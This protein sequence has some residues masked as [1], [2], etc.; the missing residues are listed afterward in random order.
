MKN[1]KA[2]N[3]YKSKLSD[4]EVKEMRNFDLIFY[5]NLWPQKENQ[6]SMELK[7]YDSVLYRYEVIE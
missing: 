6:L 1:Y 4:D 7:K 3:L 5:I 2:I